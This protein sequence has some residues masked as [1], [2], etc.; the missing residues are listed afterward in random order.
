MLA[1]RNNSLQLTCRPTRTHYPDSEPTSFCSFSLCCVFSK[2]AT[3]TILIVFG[4]IQL[5]LEP[6]IN[7]TRGKHANHYTTDAV[8]LAKTENQTD[9]FNGNRQ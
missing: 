3:N 2:E 9:N 5:G 4:L 8:P 7:R 1:H 6:T